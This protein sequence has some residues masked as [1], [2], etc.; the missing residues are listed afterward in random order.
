MVL[1]EQDAQGDQTPFGLSPTS[2]D[3]RQIPEWATER[4]QLVNDGWLGD[5]GTTGPAFGALDTPFRGAVESVE[6]LLIL[7]DMA[8]DAATGAENDATGQDFARAVI[9]M[10]G[11]GPVELARATTE[12]AT[13]SSAFTGGSIYNRDEAGNETRKKNVWLRLSQSVIPAIDRTYGTLNLDDRASE[14]ASTRIWES[15]T[16]LQVRQV[17]EKDSEKERSRQVQQ[18]VD[19]LEDYNRAHPE[20]KAPT[21]PE[22]K[23][24]GI[25]P[26]PVQD[27]RDAA[28]AASGSRGGGR[29]LFRQR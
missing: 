24:I 17:N 22:L 20:W 16:G 14:G 8:Y 1:G 7:K 29:S 2:L 11:G 25:I 6:P 15:M 5:L 21:I 26:D 19:A 23:D 18:L 13:G 3:G 12:E 4:G 10:P 28:S 9:N 27:A